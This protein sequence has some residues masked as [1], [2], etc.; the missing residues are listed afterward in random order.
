VFFAVGVA[1]L[2]F[3]FKFDGGSVAARVLATALS[4]GLVLLGLAYAIWPITG[5]H[6]NPAVTMGALVAR[7]IT[8]SDAF[9]YWVAQF[10]G[11]YAGA[12]V[13]WLVLRQSPLYSMSVQGLGTDG[14]GQSS[15]IHLSGG[16]FMAEVILTALFV[17]VILAVTGAV[18]N[19][20]TAGMVIGLTLTVVHLIGIPL[21]GTSVN[22][23]RSLGPA[24]VVGGTTLSQVWL[25]FVAP[26]VGA[27][28]AA[29]IHAVLYPSVEK[30]VIVVEIAD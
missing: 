16:A 1:T 21:T 10:L 15:L 24:L 29:I 3:G 27:F 25:F 4:F 26:L 22:P 5:C 7:R 28:L 12:L 2:M 23:A 30:S 17:F 6:V 9:N 14:Y 19:A 18:G 13:L 8:F 11:G 20:S